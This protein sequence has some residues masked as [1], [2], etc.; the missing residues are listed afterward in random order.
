MAKDALRHGDHVMMPKRLFRVNNIPEHLKK[1][2][3]YFHHGELHILV[4]TANVTIGNEQMWSLVLPW[5]Q[6]YGIHV[7]VVDGG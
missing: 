3:R 5:Q 6:V 7:H 1:T 2:Y 4:Y